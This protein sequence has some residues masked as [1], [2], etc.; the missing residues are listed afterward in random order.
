MEK[1][2]FRSAHY[3]FDGTFNGF[4]YWG[5][6]DRF[7]NIDTTSKGFASPTTRSGTER[8]YEEFFTGY[9]DKNGVELFEGDIYQVDFSSHYWI[10]VIKR[11]KE[12]NNL[13]GQLIEDNLSTD[14]NDENYTFEKR[15]FENGRFDNIIGSKCTVIGNIHEHSKLF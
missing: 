1:I 4:S 11:L 7:G 8:K 2:K 9:L 6:I 14:K 15:T 13:F 10:F 5:A 12:G 3:N